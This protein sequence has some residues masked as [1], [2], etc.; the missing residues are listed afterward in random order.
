MM[1]YYEGWSRDDGYSGCWTK[2]GNDYAVVICPPEYN[3]DP[4]WALQ[5]FDE[6]DE[7]AVEYGE[8]FELIE[9]LESEEEAFDR[10]EEWLEDHA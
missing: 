7:Q 8:V 10:A 2:R 4:D 6:A 5:I 1:D 9:H 3:D